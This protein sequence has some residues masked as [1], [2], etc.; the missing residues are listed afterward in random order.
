M[1][2]L[3]FPLVPQIDEVMLYIGWVCPTSSYADATRRY[4]GTRKFPPPHVT[5]H[6]AFTVHDRH[7]ITDPCSDELSVCHNHTS[8]CRRLQCMRTCGKCLPA[9]KSTTTTATANS[10]VESRRGGGGVGGG[11]YAQQIVA[12][13]HVSKK[14]TVVSTSD[15]FAVRYAKTLGDGGLALAGEANGE[16]MNGDDALDISKDG[17]YHH[18]NHHNPD[19]AAAAGDGGRG[20][21]RSPE[22]QSHQRRCT[23]PNSLRGTWLQRTTS[24]EDEKVV[25]TESTFTHPRLGVLECVSFTPP[26]S[27]ATPLRRVLW[28]RYD[29]G[30]YPRFTCLHYNTPAKSVMRY[31]LANVQHW[32]LVLSD[33]RICEERHFMEP[34]DMYQPGDK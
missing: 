14:A 17:D 23:F 12:A 9:A 24:G 10:L 3:L 1:V 30:C 27:E 4:S 29:N 20:G 15:R 8:F 22:R 26:G 28:S 16:S 7:V 13:G 31:R 6:M 32:P 19:T 34:P 33:D 21:G 5:P 25:I 18:H 11:G 2:Q